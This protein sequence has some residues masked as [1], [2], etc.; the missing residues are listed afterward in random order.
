MSTIPQTWGEARDRYLERATLKSRH[1]V[2][3][4]R[5]SIARFFDFVDA[6]ADHGTLPI[7]KLEGPAAQLP[8]S[9]LCADDA[10]V[11][12]AFAEWLLSETDAIGGGS[13][14]A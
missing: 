9:A 14:C 3:A 13:S 8:L 5:Q 2:A 7:Q 6:T 10:P 4:Y 12:L 11:L 1:T